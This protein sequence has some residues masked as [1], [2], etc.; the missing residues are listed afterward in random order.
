M[1]D[2]NK[3]TY[4][5]MVCT[6]FNGLS[7]EA[8][9]NEID[10]IVDFVH[11]YIIESLK[12]ES[13]DGSEINLCFYDNNICY[14]RP[15]LSDDDRD[16]DYRLMCMANG[17]SNI[18]AECDFVVF[19]PGWE[20]SRGCLAEATVA[21][22]YNKPVVALEEYVDL[23]TNRSHVEVMNPARFKLTLMKALVEGVQ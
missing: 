4:R 21:K 10:R 22:L 19:G 7:D 6:P 20:K 16:Y 3:Y 18:M 5:V 23:V 17:L 14:R 11:D 2:I 8:I 1:E 13:S 9:N 15:N 12:K